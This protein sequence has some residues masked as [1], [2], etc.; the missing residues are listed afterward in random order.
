[1]S[2][3]HLEIYFS[4]R[5]SDLVSTFSANSFDTT[6]NYPNWMAC[7]ARC[8][9]S[10][11]LLCYT[12]CKCLTLVCFS[13]VIVYF[14][15]DSFFSPLLFLHYAL[16]FSFI[17]ERFTLPV[18]NKR[19]IWPVTVRLLLTGHREGGERQKGRLIEFVVGLLQTDRYTPSQEGD[20]S[21]VSVSCLNA[22]S[23]WVYYYYSTNKSNYQGLTHYP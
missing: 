11:V 1:M 22:P 8:L 5:I 7:F 19:F 12:T 20:R 9:P 2:L 14:G 10:S 18:Y 23:F 3:T 15:F 13:P 17:T 21:W 4:S 16:H 6:Q